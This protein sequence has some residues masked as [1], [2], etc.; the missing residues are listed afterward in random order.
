MTGYLGEVDLESE[1][2]PFG[3]YTPTDWAQYY[4]DNYG[5]IGGSH[6]KQWVLDQVMRILKGTKVKVTLATWD[7]GS[8]E[9]RV[10]LDIPS[11]DY[12]DWIIARADEDYP[13]DVGCAP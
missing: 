8:C 5:G 11:Q 13:W 10:N 6:H 7:D 3:D 12:K 1:D 4:I 9:Y 2:N